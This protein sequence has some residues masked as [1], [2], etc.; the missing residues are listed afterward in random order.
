[1]TNRKMELNSKAISAYINGFYKKENALFV[2]NHS[3]IFAIIKDVYRRNL[4]KSENM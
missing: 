4:K 3:D 2:S 1:M